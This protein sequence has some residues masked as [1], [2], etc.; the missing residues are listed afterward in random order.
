LGLQ[1]TKARCNGAPAQAATI[2]V[3]GLRHVDK[4]NNDDESAETKGRVGFIN[5]GATLKIS[6]NGHSVRAYGGH[7]H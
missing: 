2:S 4:G 6:C 7:I 1:R 3:S 5:Y